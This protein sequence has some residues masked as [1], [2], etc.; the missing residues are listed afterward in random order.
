MTGPRPAAPR[1]L[2]IC[3]VTEA[4]LLAAFFLLPFMHLWGQMPPPPQGPGQSS[5]TDLASAVSVAV[6]FGLP[7]LVPFGLIVLLPEED[8]GWTRSLRIAPLV[9]VML[10]PALVA[11]GT[12][13]CC[14]SDVLDYV[15]RQRLWTVYGENPFLLVPNDHPEDWSYYFANFKDLVFSYGPVWWLIARAFTQWATSLDE[16]LLGFKALAALSFGVSAALVWRLADKHRRLVSLAFFVWNPAVLV[17]GVV[18]LHNDLLTVPF[19]L[20]AVWLWRRNRPGA[21]L[22]VTAL[23]VLVKVTVAP[24]GLALVA[25]LVQMRCWRA[26]AAGLLAS[27]AITLALYAPFWAGLRTFGALLAQAN[28]PQWS[29][30]SMLLLLG[31]PWLGGGALLLVRLVLGLVCLALI[32]VAL[33]QHRLEC[34]VADVTVVLMVIVLLLLPLAFYSHYLMPAVAL[35]A[36]A[37]DRRVRWL[38][39]AV[40]F[41]AMVNAVLGVDTFAGGPTDTVL[42]VTGSVV[43]LT[44]V[45]A[46]VLVATRSGV[47]PRSAAALP[48]AHR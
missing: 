21:S 48:S 9:G 39:L 43:L 3:G 23:G 41:G 18:R 5:S 28:R 14:T 37:S 35:A 27:V 22:V 12:Y 16:Y 42:D 13:P 26:I 4:A 15:N 45:A 1:W 19:A 44:A 34:R 25:A 7:S 11:L 10:L 36:I 8:G 47:Q 46:G 24:L 32:G 30:G 20:A 29:L 6:I 40:G 2:P 31:Q 17:E 38:V 33:R